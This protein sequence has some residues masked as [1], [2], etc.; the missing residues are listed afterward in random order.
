MILAN[1][2]GSIWSGVESSHRFCIIQASPTLDQ[3]HDISAVLQRRRL[4]VFWTLRYRRS[5]AKGVSKTSHA[6]HLA[7][8]IFQF[9][10]HQRCQSSLGFFIH[11]KV[12]L[13]VRSQNWLIKKRFHQ[14]PKVCTSSGSST[15]NSS[16]KAILKNQNFREKKNLASQE[17]NAHRPSG[18]LW[19]D[20]LTTYLVFKSGQ[21]QFSLVSQ[22]IL[23]FG[24]QKRKNLQNSGWTANIAWKSPHSS[25]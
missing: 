3:I 11:S 16:S 10:I 17:Q 20:F 13:L 25:E 15:S 19:N 4:L 24:C 18:K 2:S 21:I 22:T 7:M 14:R 5:S 6:T 12:T 23:T 8:Q 1:F 9:K